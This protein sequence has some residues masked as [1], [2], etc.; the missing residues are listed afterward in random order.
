MYFNILISLSD[1]AEQMQ[2]RLREESR[3]NKFDYEQLLRN[4]LGLRHEEIS[5]LL[6]DFITKRKNAILMKHVPYT[7]SPD[8]LLSK[9]DLD[10]RS[11][12]NVFVYRVKVIKS[13]KK[14]I[15]MA[16]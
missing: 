4:N 9:L 6:N 7:I 14:V 3:H 13:E 5:N 15:K 8:A 1:W 10:L 11:I 16:N 2:L 12:R